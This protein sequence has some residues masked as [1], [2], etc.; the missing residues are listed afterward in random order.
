M[1]RTNDKGSRFHHLKKNQLMEFFKKRYP[2]VVPAVL[3][4]SITVALV[5]TST[6]RRSKKADSRE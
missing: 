2:K 4:A 6:R 3:Q 5:L 1:T